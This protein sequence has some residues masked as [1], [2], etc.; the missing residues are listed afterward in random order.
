M[1]KILSL[2]ALVLFSC[3]GAWAQGTSVHEGCVSELP[4]AASKQS[5]VLSTPR[6]TLFNSSESQYL[7]ATCFPDYDTANPYNANE[8]KFQYLLFP[9]G[10]EHGYYIY[11]VAVGKFLGNRQEVTKG[12]NKAGA[13]VM[14]DTP[15]ERFI[16]AH[17]KTGTMQQGY[18][19]TFSASDYPYTIGMS[20]K[21][22]PYET[23]NLTYW[24]NDQGYDF[25]STS[26]IDGGNAFAVVPAAEVSDEVYT[27]AYTAAYGKAPASYE[28]N[29]KLTFSNITASSAT[30]SVVDGEGQPISGVSATLESIASNQA[31][32]DMKTGNLIPTY[33]I[34]SPNYS[35]SVDGWWELTFKIEG[36]K[37]YEFNT[38][39]TD[40]HGLNAQ[41]GPQMTDSKLWQTDFK[42]GNAADAIS[43][44]VT[45]PAEELV[46]GY[47]N[48][49]ICHHNISATALT[50]YTTS[51]TEPLYITVRMTKTVGGGCHAG[52]A[53]LEL[54]NIVGLVNVT[55][56]Y[57]IGDDKIDT[58]TLQAITGKEYPEPT[59]AYAGYNRS[60]KPEGI[61]AEGGTHSIS[62]TWGGPFE[63]TTVADG[64]FAEGTKWYYMQNGLNNGN[65]YAY[66]LNDSS[67]K[68][69]F[70]TTETNDPA[71]KW[72][73]VRKAGTP[74]LYLY[75]KKAGAV[76]MRELLN[77]RSDWAADHNQSFVVADET[78]LEMP[79]ELFV[80]NTG[81]GFRLSNDAGTCILGKHTD[82]KLSVWGKSASKTDNGSR[83]T[84]T[85]APEDVPFDIAPYKAAAISYVDGFT[86]IPA[87]FNT[88]DIDA[89]K[90]AINAVT[91]EGNDDATI[92]A[93][94]AALETAKENL[95]KTAANKKFAVKT[96]QGNHNYLYANEDRLDATNAEKTAAAV[97][98]LV[99]DKDC[100]FFLHGLKNDVYV[101]KNTSTREPANVASETSAAG[102]V[103]VGKLATTDENTVYFAY[104]LTGWNAIHYNSNYTGYNCVW[105]YDAGASQWAIEA[106]S[107]AEWEALTAVPEGKDWEAYETRLNQLKAY[108]I[109]EGLGKYAD[110]TKYDDVMEDDV[111]LSAWISGFEFDLEYEA[112]EYYD[113]DMDTMQ[114]FLEHMQINQPKPGS[115][116]RIKGYT[117]G[118]YISG[119]G[120]S[121]Q[122]VLVNEANASSV[123]YL[124]ESNH[125]I[126]YVNGRGFTDTHSVAPVGTFE[127]HTFSEAPF[128]KG[129]YLIK[130][131]YSGSK[132]LCD[133]TDGKLN[134]WGSENDTRSTWALEEVETLPVS[135]S[136]AGFATL[137]APV[138]L[139]VPAN[140]EAYTLAFDGTYLQATAVEGTI[141]ANT[142][143]VLKAAAG[144]YDFAITTGGTATSA[145]RG[146]V[147]T[148]A[149]V[150]GALVL[151]LDGENVGFYSLKEEVAN[152]AGFKAYYVPTSGE[153][154]LRV[155]F[156]NETLTSIISAAKENGGQAIYDLQGR[157][158]VSAKGLN[159]I[160]GKKVIR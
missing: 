142:G 31:N 9:T 80:N 48:G 37:G 109:G 150:E 126:G 91:C 8:A 96:T 10:N 30:V 155:V 16:Y 105:S 63:L 42:L 52:I 45:A 24:N 139:T 108:T 17:G 120:T 99:Y 128:A 14:S 68:S 2:L 15:V 152:L 73:F 104:E 7:L 129:K 5:Y 132:V 115:F 103:Y 50:S 58:E 133:W 151:G 148:I 34:L 138:A 114:W 123:L 78:A 112:E 127:A 160:N 44:Y 90:A 62:L 74:Y 61:V 122:A 106:V 39:T 21:N 107:D 141:P 149:K 131:D 118:K 59:K 23:I 82:S 18:S 60:A 110:V 43:D 159:I 97:Y 19:G 93:A 153:S 72:A 71:Y 95:L 57:Y 98:E 3:M 143:V 64:E 111:P 154:N 89:A 41:G 124:D 135:V 65:G 26:N 83:F 35:N 28:G 101:C 11:N 125:L 53:S 145:L 32:H 100:K 25:G 70:N 6:G 116:L 36:L 136:A 144:S 46:I 1:K 38:L 47:Y 94:L 49:T 79:L 119:N 140:V 54:S 102:N 69:G 92:N 4:S 20:V 27:Q 87:L 147:P 121:G 84:F 33:G 130:S 156:D 157:R 40:A 88:T 51:S 66:Y 13:C 86:G 134:R 67:K 56:D 158:V 81:Y 22:G 12:S 85:E 75:N 137:Y 77:T 146:T 117:S 113:D 29:L 76:A 55:Y